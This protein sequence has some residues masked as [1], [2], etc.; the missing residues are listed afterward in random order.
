[1]E[2]GVV[3]KERIVN[4]SCS[5]S[6]GL[7][8]QGPRL[9]TNLSKAACTYCDTIIKFNQQYEHTTLNDVAVVEGFGE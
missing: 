2:V 4:H 3:K 1:M 9:W 7:G 8:K 6:Q 5:R